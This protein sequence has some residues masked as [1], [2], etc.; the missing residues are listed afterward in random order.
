MPTAAQLNCGISKNSLSVCDIAR[1]HRNTYIMETRR[2][3]NGH[4]SED[5]TP[6]NTNG[7]IQNVQK[8]ASDTS[9]R[10]DSPRILYIVFISLLIDL[11]GFTVI[12][13]LLPSLLDYY[14]KNSNDG[15]YQMLVS[16]VNSFRDFIGVPNIE[17]YNSVLFG[18]VISSLFS[19][20]QFVA[21]PVVGSAS[22]VYGRR[23][24]MLL[25]MVG[26]AISYA[27]WAVSRNFTVFV[28]ARIIGGISK[29]NVSLSTAIVTDASSVKNRGKGMALIG[30]AFSLGFLF[31]P[32][33]GAYFAKIATF[34]QGEFY[35]M[36]ALFALSL[37]LLD[38]VFLYVFLEETLPA[39]KR[40]PSFSSSLKEAHNLLSPYALFQFSA[41]KRCPEKDLGTLRQIGRSYFLYLFLY[42]G[43]EFTLT[44]LV[45]NRFQYTSMEQGKMF[46]FIGV[47]MALVQGGYSRRVP[48]G[49]EKKVALRGMLIL[50]PAFI[51]IAFASSQAVL[52]IGLALFSFASATVVP[53]MTTMVSSYGNADQKGT[54][55]GIFR[56]LGAL[57]RAVGPVAASTIYW[58]IGS[59][60][61]YMIGGLLL[62]IPMM[63]LMKVQP[64]KAMA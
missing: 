19:F 42:S 27:L 26:I 44:F 61:C 36:P 63:L 22:D 51:I 62:V 57:A 56:S 38:V 40:A 33:I 55:V 24:L 2:R 58:S 47:I 12:L 45:H 20:L 28:I 64:Q 5:S 9:E 41:V 37:A 10:T 13:P 8:S 3:A 29:G 15:L 60:F 16:Q 49:A 21:S 52:Y 48:Q 25:C 14:G 18:G 31:G 30:V 32:S 17:K 54:V 34:R 53:C 59:E 1:V 4:L 46:L 11:L 23:P 50:V 7:D 35:T 43:L 39:G 6:V